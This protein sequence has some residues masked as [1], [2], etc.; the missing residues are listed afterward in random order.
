M[1]LSLWR[2]SHLVLAISSALFLIIAS[3]TGIILAFEPISNSIQPYVVNNLHEI[4]LGE[5]IQTL[6]NEYDEVLE[7][8]VTP[9]DFVIAS[10][11][12]KDGESQTGYI[13]PIT[14]KILG[15]V[16]E[17]APIFSFTTNLHRS[18]FL[19]SIGRF[20]IG[21]VSL[22]LCLIAVTGL[23]VLA[24]RQGGFLKLYTKV[25]ERNFNQRYHVILGRWLLY[26]ILILAITGVYLSAEKFSLLPESDLQHH[27][28]VDG[29]ENKPSLDLIDF[30]IFKQTSLNEVRKITFP[31]SEDTEDYYEVALLDKELFIHQY[32]GAVVSELTYPFVRVAS[33]LSFRLHTGQGSVLWSLVLLV[34][35]MSIL[36]FI[37][38]G[39][40]MTLKRSKKSKSEK[41]IVSQGKDASEYILLVG[42]ETGN[43][44]TFAR[45]V[46]RSLVQQGKTVFMSSLNEYSTYKKATH[47]LI[48]TATY[49]D[50]DA[51]TNARNFEKLVAKITPITPLKFAVV[52]FGSSIYPKY[53][54]FAIRVDALLHKNP[55]Y[56]PVM[57]LHK[58]DDQSED[59]FQHWVHDW[60]THTEMSLQASIRQNKKKLHSFTVVEKT[61]LNKDD[62]FIL[63]LKSAKRVPFQSGDLVAITP[64]NET[65]ARQYSV[66]K[67]DKK[68]VLSVKKHDQGKCSSYMS[69]LELGNK[70]SGTLEKNTK[71]HFPKHARSIICIANGT[72]IAPFL[73]MIEENTKQIP[74]H[75]F[76]G[77][78]TEESFAMYEKFMRRALSR[79]RIKSYKNAYSREGNQQYVQDV[80]ATKRALI[81][82]VL[83][84]GGA[85]MICGSLA[86]QYQVLEL[87][88]QVSNEEL[89]RPLIYF[90]KNQQ[91]FMDCY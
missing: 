74:M 40:A 38:S 90:E 2:Y 83:T 79:K 64:E 82:E 21:L 43:T 5:T 36:F 25:Q 42:S 34:A 30:P 45:A 71:F 58:I 44:Y 39:I 17:R 57:P 69:T 27:W 35:S 91:L 78:R 76:W 7:F 41:P 73:G 31:F 89:K 66:A 20:F 86:M 51:P 29:T 87:L 47:L 14:G 11:I 50:G 37:Y 13:D 65:K 6:K 59:S 70:I 85:I 19:K 10:V 68:I 84:T 4:S 28:D 60:N 67:I 80:L 72:G 54:R 22:L 49:G 77:G 81:A 1:V 63:Q 18:L 26:P 23:L 15:E 61:D 53:C 46:H 3:I 8:E 62:T 52:G 33:Q 55:M 12:T 75:I 9:S 24:Q 56:Q 16:K 32:N 88:E 48:F